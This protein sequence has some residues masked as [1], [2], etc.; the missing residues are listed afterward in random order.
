MITFSRLEFL[1]QM[2]KKL[3]KIVTL[4]ESEF[5]GV[6]DLLDEANLQQA[7]KNFRT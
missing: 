1:F 7:V 2:K 6:A 4:P 5:G 3:K